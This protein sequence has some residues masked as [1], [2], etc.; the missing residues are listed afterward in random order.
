MS[1]AVSERFARA[2]LAV[3]PLVLLVFVAATVFLAWQAL[4]IRV[5]TDVSKM[6]PLQHPYIQNFMEHRDELNVGNDVRII[7]EDVKHDD[8]FNKPYMKALQE[9]S[10]DV[11]SLDGVDPST[12]QS[13][14]GDA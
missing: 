11:Y 9:I 14:P 8:I 10:D 1:Q 13:Q 5:N 7:V 4:Q 12:I 3:R 6:V 2:L